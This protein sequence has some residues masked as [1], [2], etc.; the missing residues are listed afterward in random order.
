MLPQQPGRSGEPWQQL[1]LDATTPGFETSEARWFGAGRLPEPVLTWFSSSPGI[2]EHRCDT[3]RVDGSLVLGVKRRNGSGL[4][5]KVRR[6]VAGTLQLS[7]DL[8]A[9]I[10]HWVKVSG[11]DA[12]QLQTN[13][14]A[15]WVEVDKVVRSRIYRLGDGPTASLAPGRDLTSPGCDVEIAAVVIRDTE[16]WTFAF[17]AW[18]PEATR[19]TLLEATAAAVRAE[20][21]PPELGHELRQAVGYPEW[22]AGLALVT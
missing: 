9:P 10:E 20:G 6:A 7:D 16:A 2:I 15:Y 18:G 13:R 5:A 11:L 1:G 3:Y 4:E 8:T 19:L 21:M 17:E 14:E 22:L 12:A